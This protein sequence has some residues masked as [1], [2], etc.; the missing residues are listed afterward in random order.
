MSFNPLPTYVTRE[1]GRARGINHASLSP[2]L[3]SVRG[4]L[5]TTETNVEPEVRGHRAELKKKSQT[6]FITQRLCGS[7]LLTVI[8]DV[9]KAAMVTV[10]GCLTQLY[11]HHL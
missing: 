11:D 4:D 10:S 5:P 9:P 8:P 2:T 6:W 1:W 7:S 3:M